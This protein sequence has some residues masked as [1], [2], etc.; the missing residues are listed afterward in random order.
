MRGAKV[1]SDAAKAAADAVLRFA[2][3]TIGDRRGRVAL[4]GAYLLHDREPGL[5]AVGAVV[6]TL[7]AASAELSAIYAEESPSPNLALEALDNA[8][9]ALTAL[10][11]LL[12]EVSR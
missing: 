11:A 2:T 9:R 12:A 1:K 7:D 5:N 3:E 10:R 8:E 6:A 4:A